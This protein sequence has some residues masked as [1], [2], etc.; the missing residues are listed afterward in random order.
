MPEGGVACI[1]QILQAVSLLSASRYVNSLINTGGF[2]SKLT[3]PVELSCDEIFA[4]ELRVRL[5]K[6]T[7]F[8]VIEV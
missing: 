1:S 3:V 7:V 8:G 5:V 6:H 4:T 2:V